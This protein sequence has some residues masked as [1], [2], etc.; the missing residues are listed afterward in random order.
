MNSRFLFPTFAVVLQ[1][2]FASR[3]TP[4]NQLYPSCFWFPM[5][6][7]VL[8]IKMII[9]ILHI[10]M[11]C[12]SAP[13]LDMQPFIIHCTYDMIFPISMFVCSKSIWNS[14]WFRLVFFY[15]APNRFGKVC[16]SIYKSICKLCEYHVFELQENISLFAF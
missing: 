15:C 14:L 8:Q 3:K 12:R 11:N 16:S 6:V 7:V 4:W 13:D 5:L 10:C 2:N 9:L 1:I